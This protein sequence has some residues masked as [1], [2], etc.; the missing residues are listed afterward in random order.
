MIG[1]LMKLAEDLEFA[2]G[3]VRSK[4]DGTSEIDEADCSRTRKCCED[5]ALFNEFECVEIQVF[6][7]TKPF[8]EVFVGRD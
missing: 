4:G 2:S 8:F 7:G 3:I 6:I 5:P 1:R